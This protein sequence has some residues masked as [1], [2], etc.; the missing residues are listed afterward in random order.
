MCPHAWAGWVALNFVKVPSGDRRIQSAEVCAS[1]GGTNPVPF[2][3]L[4]YPC[5]LCML[6]ATDARFAIMG[7]QRNECLH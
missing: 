1:L 7:V 5:T 4:L 6:H 3:L 2:K